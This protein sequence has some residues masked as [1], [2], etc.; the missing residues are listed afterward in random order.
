MAS[1]STA[2]TA[3]KSSIDPSVNKARLRLKMQPRLAAFVV[4]MEAIDSL[5][6]EETRSGYSHLQS[7][8]PHILGQGF[9]ILT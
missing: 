9:A 7:L 2:W 6:I 3:D 4:E 5:A 1:H 8:H